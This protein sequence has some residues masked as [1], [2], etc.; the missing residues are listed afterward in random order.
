[1][2]GLIAIYVHSV[3][4]AAFPSDAVALLFLIPVL[5]CLRLITRRVARGTSPFKPDNYHFH[6]MLDQGVPWRLGLLIY[7]SLIAV[8]N[9]VAFAMPSLT[10]YLI[11]MTILIY[12]AVILV[13]KAHIVTRRES[14]N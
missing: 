1:M 2:I 9:L 8:P 3:N 10:I 13:A 6:H 4:F 12:A 14:T 7:L 11:A 5:D